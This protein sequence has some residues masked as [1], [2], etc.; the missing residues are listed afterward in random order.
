MVHTHICMDL[1][2]L[3]IS[4]CNKILNGLTKMILMTLVKYDFHFKKVNLRLLSKL[5]VNSN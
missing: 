2:T 3:E 1:Y 4:K 5:A